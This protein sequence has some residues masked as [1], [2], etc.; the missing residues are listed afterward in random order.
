MTQDSLIIK[1]QIFNQNSY[2]SL[3]NT[4][5]L[6]DQIK[7]LPHRENEVKKIFNAFQS[8]L[9]SWP[10]VHLILGGLA[11]SGKSASIQLIEKHF[12]EEGLIES[13]IFNKNK[14]KNQK[15]LPRVIN[16]DCVEFGTYTKILQYM[17][18]NYFSEDVH[19]KVIRKLNIKSSVIPD[20]GYSQF[21]YFLILK[22]CFIEDRRSTLFVFDKFDKIQLNKTSGEMLDTTKL[23]IGLNQLSNYLKLHY[24][25]E[26]LKLSNILVVSDL[27]TL[28]DLLEADA[29][30]YFYKQ[31]IAFSQYNS[32]E[33][34]SILE[35]RLPAFTKDVISK[36]IIKYIG[37]HVGEAN[38]CARYGINLLRDSARLAQEQQLRHVTLKEVD[39]AISRYSI[40]Y[41]TNIVKD[42][43]VH[44]MLVLISLY[45]QYITKETDS[46]HNRAVS[47]GKIYSGYVSLI[48]QVNETMNSENYLTNRDYRT[49]TRYLKHLVEQGIIEK[50]HLKGIY[51]KGVHVSYKLTEKYSLESITNS[52]LDQEYTKKFD[53][54]GVIDGSV[55]AVI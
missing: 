46:G 50:T 31:E 47:T 22:E 26:E 28:D 13:K 25:T 55:E 54:T 35:S 4:D 19:Q 2:L 6:P 42:F 45:H 18:R 51:K 39:K 7:E 27:E 33:I 32:V 43:S 48:N 8:L 9:P 1:N 12:A 3:L 37:D 53:L 44:Y 5:I 14:T 20:R 52:L 49:V 40:D 17:I 30:N 29:L 24:P 11:G 36:D 16:V 23:I 21:D 41:M 34:Q 10:E 38:G 15:P